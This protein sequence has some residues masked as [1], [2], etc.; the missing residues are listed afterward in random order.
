RVGA[1]PSST[2]VLNSSSVRYGSWYAPWTWGSSA[3][4][5]QTPEL[6]PA[7]LDHPAVVD[8]AQKL[9]FLKE[10]GLDYGWGTSAMFQ[11]GIE[12]LHI[13]YGLQ[14][15]AAILAASVMIRLIGLPFQ[16]RASN[17][18]AKSQAIAPLI[19]PIRDE[20]TAAI[21]A[22]DTV[23]SEELRQK[24]SMM[25]AASG[26]NPLGA[27]LPMLV[28]IPF[29]FGAFRCT[30]GMSTLPVESMR[31]Q[32]F[33]WFSDLTVSDPYYI[34]PVTVAGLGFAMF[35]YG[36]ETGVKTTSEADSSQQVMQSMKFVMP[37]MMGT[38]CAWMP[39]GLQLY[40]L[41]TSVL[42]MSTGLVLRRPGVRSVLGLTQ[43]ITDAERSIVGRIAKGESTL[44]PKGVTDLYQV[45][46]NSP[47]L[48]VRPGAL[49][50]SHMQAEKKVE[51]PEEE[52]KKGMPKEAS[53]T[54]QATWV[55]KHYNPTAMA[56]RVKQRYSAATKKSVDKVEEVKQEVKKQREREFE[57]R[58]RVSKGRR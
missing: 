31:D 41:S 9:G 33:L 7:T 48:N 17:N 21:R 42:S 39:A 34:L 4:T 19:A 56:G 26:T 11:W 28:Q 13:T 8:S 46:N 49:R 2:V 35:K 14:W 45:K 5:T 44:G 37:L 22:K 52:F 3:V 43:V 54:D 16:I 30:R 20:M 55:V 27:M 51:S 53:K 25:Y 18:Q 1:S 24:I 23:A 38:F 6:S 58:R 47:Q 50:P 36:G 15:G 29:G 10:L 32:G 57:T 12:H 40:F